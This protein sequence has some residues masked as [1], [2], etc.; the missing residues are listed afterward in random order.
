MHK[1]VFSFCLIFLSIISLQAQ[2]T[3]PHIIFITFD[4]LNDYVEGFDGSLQIETPTLKELEESGA[5]FYNAY[6]ASP[7]CGPSR[8]SML[9]GKDL[10]YTQVYNNKQHKCKDFRDNFTEENNNE[11]VFTLPEYLKDSAGYFTYSLNKI[12]HCYQNAIDYDSITPDMCEKDLSWNKV[13][14]YEDTAYIDAVG[15]LIL[16]GPNTFPWALLEDSLE[17]KM[18]DYAIIDSAIAFLQ[19]YNADPSVACNKPLF[20]GLGFMK[21][22]LP[23]F[24]PKSYYSDMYEDLY[25]IPFDYPFNNPSNTYPANGLIMPPQPDPPYS[26]FDALPFEGVAASLADASLENTF[27]EFVADLDPPP[28]IDESLTDSMR[29]YV[30]QQS[31]RA[32]AIMGYMAAIKFADAQLGRFMEVLKTYPDIYNNCVIIALGD[33]GFSLGEKRH[34]RKGAMWETDV[35][36]PLIYVDMRNPHKTV[37]ERQV[38]FTD[39]FPT[40]CDIAG[41]NYPV[42][43]DGSPYLDG[44]SFLPL[45][46]NPDT[47]YEHPILTSYIEKEFT[48]QGGCFPQYSVRS[49]RFHYIT[50]QTNNEYGV[51]DCDFSKSIR[52]EELYELGTQRQ[53]DPYEWNN[54]IL[55]PDYKPVV[56]Y[57]QQWMPDSAL[58]KKKTYKAFIQNNDIPCYLGASDVLHMSFDLYDVNGTYLASKPASLTYKWFTNKTDDTVYAESFDLSMADVPGF[59]TLGRIM[60]YLEVI[61]G[62]DVIVALDMRYYF[63]NDEPAPIAAFNTVMTDYT[64]TIEDYILVGTYTDSWWDFGDGTILHQYLPLPYTYESPGVYTIKNY[65][66]YGNDCVEV[67]Q[68][69]VTIADIPKLEVGNLKVYPNPTQNNITIQLNA[70]DN[71]GT[72]YISDMLGNIVATQEVLSAGNNNFVTI[73]VSHLAKGAYALRFAGKNMYSAIFVVN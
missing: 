25:S 29:T 2:S 30:L 17:S 28:V 4:D 66:Q 36:A 10:L 20:L 42:F 39:I 38:S 13:F 26:D 37:T 71:T 73:N 9:S 59:D 57:L 47:I 6:C 70:N 45:L 56:S 61:D 33:H 19:Q 27:N 63:L 11:E 21:P 55:N 8:A 62:S 65:V 58:Y 35:R 41:V 3:Q 24:I 51:S 50:Y 7:Q 40:L 43:S 5:L 14:V 49:D 48:D 69:D 68:T 64:A 52:E 34:W 16:E 15:N 23:Y 44:I 12:L 46:S 72:V 54:L 31:I 60:V 18:A 32:N 1:F 53:T 67:F 22:H